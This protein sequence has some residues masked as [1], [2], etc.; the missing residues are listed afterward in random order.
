M[1]LTNNLSNSTTITSSINPPKRIRIESDDW[2]DKA[3]RSRLLERW[4]EQD[5]YI[6]YLE[7]RLH[8][9]QQS[10]ES[11]D[12]VREKE[13]ECKKLKSMLNY[14]FLTKT[15]Q[16]QSLDQMR[17]MIQT[18]T[19][20][21]LRQTYL[22]PSVNLIYGQMREEIEHSR[23]ARDEA[24]NELQ[25]WKFTSDSK[26]GKMLMARCKKLLDENEQLGKIVSSD[27]VAKL[28]GETA[29]Q[30]RLLSN[31]KDAQKDYEEIL[32]DMDTNMD[33]MSSTLLHMRQQLNDSHRQI[34]ILN[35]ENTRLKTLCQSTN[36]PLNTPNG[37][38]HTDSSSITSTTNAH[39]NK[40]PQ[41]RSHSSNRTTPQNINTSNKIKTTNLYDAEETISP[42]P[43]LPQPTSLSS[44]EMMDVE[45][46]TLASISTN[47]TNNNI[48]NNNNNNENL[49]RTNSL[50]NGINITP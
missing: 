13:T 46:D 17:D 8:Q 39:N 44:N 1:D 25:A 32:L 2:I 21:R 41:K 10:I 47:S 22:D 42:P 36:N 26:T 9:L 37:T 7:L 20:G 29:L 4:K 43:P 38:T 30:N 49:K 31:I 18:P 15:T 19:L 35:E 34:T 40:L 50:E 12:I 45:T 33:A 11:N 14:R 3:P 16:Q 48:N 27:N 24:Q 5:L 6:D 23:K 28:E